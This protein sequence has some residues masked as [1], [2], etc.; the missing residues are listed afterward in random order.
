[1][2]CCTNLAAGALGNSTAARSVALPRTD[3]NDPHMRLGAAASCRP[4]GGTSSASCTHC[5][6]AA[7]TFDMQTCPVHLGGHLTT[8]RGLG[9]V[10]ANFYKVVAC[11]V[12]SRPTDALAHTA[13]LEEV[14]SRLSRTRSECADCKTNL[15]RLHPELKAARSDGRLCAA[16][17]LELVALTTKAQML[18]KTWRNPTSRTGPLVATTR[19]STPSPGSAQLGS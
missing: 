12:H 4:T 17:V 9:A 2:S 6:S 14:C 13:S 1:M 19:A 7:K 15:L 5:A 10:P 3:P 8:R 18:S 11:Q 16:L